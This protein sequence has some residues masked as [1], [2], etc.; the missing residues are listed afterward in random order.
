LGEKMAQCPFEIIQ[1]GAIKLD[2]NYN[3]I[4][5]FNRYVKPTVYPEISNLITE[6]TG[7]T[8]EQLLSEAFFPEVYYEYMEFIGDRDT[9]FCT[10]GMSDMK[11]LFRNAAYHKVDKKRLPNMYINIQ[12]YAS[13][14]LD[15]SQS[16]LLSLQ[17]AVELLKILTP[18][19]YHNALYDA[20]YTAEIFKKV[21]LTTIL[22]KR[23]DPNFVIQRPRQTKKIVD[24]EKIILQFEKM[25]AR[26][27][28]KEE[29]DMIMLA[30]KMGKTNQFF[31]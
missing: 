2:L 24:Y 6:L 9:V 31:K 28:N 29:Q 8:T 17:A 13:K 25:Y 15:A 18:Y 20:Y 16:K 10:W 12:P 5:T 14:H 4:A 7:I 11:E 23:Y 21:N 3:T 30:Y 19:E 1:I 27:L 22:A 26:E